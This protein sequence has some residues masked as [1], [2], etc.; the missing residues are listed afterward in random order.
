MLCGVEGVIKMNIRVLF[1]LV[2]FKELCVKF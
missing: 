1:M 2:F